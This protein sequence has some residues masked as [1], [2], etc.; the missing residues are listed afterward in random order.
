MQRLATLFIRIAPDNQ[1][2]STLKKAPYEAL[3][4]R[5]LD[6]DCYVFLN[7]YLFSITDNFSIFEIN[8]GVKHQVQ[9]VVH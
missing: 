7:V 1:R 2:L 3:F 4:L 6:G 9:H 5:V 8:G